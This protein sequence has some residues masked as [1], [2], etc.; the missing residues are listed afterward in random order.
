MTLPQYDL[1]GTLT[2]L[3]FEG[4]EWNMQCR[5]DPLGHGGSAMLAF[6]LFISFLCS[7]FLVKSCAHHCCRKHRERKSILRFGIMNQRCQDV[8]LLIFIFI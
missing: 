2:L 4:F 5:S 7:Q 8:S 6:E 1:E 3:Y